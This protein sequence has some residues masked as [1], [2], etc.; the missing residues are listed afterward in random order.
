MCNN[1]MLEINAFFIKRFFKILKKGC[2][3]R[4]NF[5]LK[6]KIPSWGKDPMLILEFFLK[7]NFPNPL[8]FLINIPECKNHEISGKKFKI[9]KLGFKNKSK[10][11]QNFNIQTSCINLAKKKNYFFKKHSR[12]LPPRYNTWGM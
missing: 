9:H 8:C 6:F 11:C 10:F 1:S 12:V 3:N 5:K 7:K 4:G 2:K